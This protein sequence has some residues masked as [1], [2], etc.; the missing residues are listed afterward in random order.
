MNSEQ[1]KQLYEEIKP[2]QE[3][4]NKINSIADNYKM[5]IH[6]DDSVE[7]KYPDGGC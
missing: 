7:I 4:I 5:V 2:Y 6:S 1:H 3:L